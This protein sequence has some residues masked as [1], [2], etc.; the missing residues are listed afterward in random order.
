MLGYDV[1]PA[2][3]QALLEDADW[4]AALE[5]G[6]DVVL[7]EENLRMTPAERVRQLVEM[8]AFADR[9]EGTARGP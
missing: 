9:V 5:M 7:L 8:L 1:P 3:P 4:R 2:W 6:V